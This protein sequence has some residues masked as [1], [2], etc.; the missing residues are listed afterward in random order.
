M[1]QRYDELML[2]KT[3]EEWDDIAARLQIPMSAIRSTRFWLNN[4]HARQ[5]QSIVKVDDP[6]LGE[7][8]MPG[9]P[10]TLDGAPLPVT[11]PRHLP[12]ADRDKVLA[13]PQA[14]VLALTAPVDQSYIEAPAGR[15]LG[16]RPDAG[17]RRSDRGTGPGRL[18]R[19]G[20]QGQQPRRYACRGA[21][22]AQPWQAHALA[23][24]PVSNGQDVFWRLVDRADV[25]LDNLASDAMQRYGLGYDSIHAR[26]PEIVYA[27]L[28]A[29]ARAGR[30]PAGVGMRTRASAS[31]A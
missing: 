17:R 8:W 21:A 4:A 28:G 2:T 7:T 19:R 31:P 1:E 6:E 5:S 20:D 12:D 25:V 13:G 14:R 11:E 27:A 26:K 24:H 29:F 23:R 3:A 22:A 15:L 18:R 30:G 9:Q 16:D 10:L